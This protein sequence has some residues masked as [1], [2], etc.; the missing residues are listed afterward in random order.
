MLDKNRDGSI[1][2]SELESALRDL[3]PE[4]AKPEELQKMMEEADEDGSRT[5]DFDE[6]MNLFDDSL[7][8]AAKPT[9]LS[10]AT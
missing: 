7:A 8:Q 6:F 9:G 1:S 2:M 3:E 4:L 10:S 5:I